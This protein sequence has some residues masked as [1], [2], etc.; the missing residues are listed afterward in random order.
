MA[1]QA[2]KHLKPATKKWWISVTK[3]FSLDAQ[4]LRI[5]TLAAEAWDRGEQARDYLNENG[6][7]YTDR[8]GQPKSR[9][10]VSIERD[11]RLGF[12]RMIRELCLDDGPDDT[13]PPRSRGRN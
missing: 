6:L 8:F 5:L 11:S 13:R 1:K 3:Q 4:Y 7:T 12:A 10:E 2:P 9:P